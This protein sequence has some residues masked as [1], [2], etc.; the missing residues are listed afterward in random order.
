M[1]SGAYYAASRGVG[2]LQLL[3]PGLVLCATIALA[4]SFVSDQYGGPKFLFALLLGMGFH[5][6]AD[7]TKTLPGIE[8]SAKKLV[9]VG[10][11]LL[12]ARITFGDVDALGLTGVLVLVGTVVFTIL[13][14][15]QFARALKLPATL[16][17]LSGGGTGI[18]GI[19]A[20]L[21]ISSTLPQSRENE[22]HTLLTAIGV[23]TLSTAAMI[24][25]PLVVAILD[26]NSR[27]AGLFLGGAIHDVAQVVGAGF[28]ISADV[29][30]SATLTKMF[31]VAMLVPVVF[32]LAFWLRRDDKRDDDGNAR[33]GAERQTL[34]PFFLM[35]FAGL[36]VINSFGLISPPV[37]SAASTVSSWCLVISIAALGVK[38]S[39]EKL[40][41]LGW[42]PIVLM[43]GEA[44]FVAFYMLTVVFAMRGLGLNELPGSSP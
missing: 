27:E 11:A 8:L 30:D 19:S 33:G 26:L 6:L 37:R 29:G 3:L 32:A 20:T 43:T 13:F 18:C 39:F 22:H 34:L 38:S 7:N 14:G 42:R 28:M 21:A 31:R 12:G 2:R 5:F 17:L 25:Y 15:V 23:A 35:A 16:G 41:Q 9:R 44:V 1:S 36:V 4:A 24:L 40:I 10:V